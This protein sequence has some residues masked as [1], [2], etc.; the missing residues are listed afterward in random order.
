MTRVLTG[1]VA[2]L[3]VALLYPATSRAGVQRTITF[4]AISLDPGQVSGS[5]PNGTTSVDCSTITDCTAISPDPTMGDHNPAIVFNMAA[6]DTLTV[7]A[8]IWL[9]DLD[10]PGD[11]PAV[12][13]PTPLD[14]PEGLSRIRIVFTPPLDDGSSLSMV[15]L[16]TASDGTACPL[17][18]CANYPSLGTPPPDFCPI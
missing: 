3:A 7:E 13:P 9:P 4:E 11:P 10:C 18:A 1:T 5:I 14:R 6:A 12:V 16:L 2:I 8:G 15:W 17:T